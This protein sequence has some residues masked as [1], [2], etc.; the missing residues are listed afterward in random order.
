MAA[1]GGA[2]PWPHANPAYG[3]QPAASSVSTGYPVQ[4]YPDPEKAGQQPAQP[5]P[6]SQVYY[7]K[8]K[9]RCCGCGVQL[10]LF[11]LGWVLSLLGFG[12]IL[13][14][15]GALLPTCAPQLSRGDNRCGWVSNLVAASVV[16]SLWVI[17]LV[18]AIYANTVA[19][20]DFAAQAFSDLEF[21][22]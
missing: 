4:P 17:A 21:M 19:A 5:I 1:T 12:P 8:K 11:V 22:N 9:E 2:R 15:V 16:T 6:D 10:T 13:W 14:Y 18:A 20:E 7:V 3:A